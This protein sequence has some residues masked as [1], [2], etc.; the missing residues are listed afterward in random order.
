L[1]VAFYVKSADELN[2]IDSVS[3][4]QSDAASRASSPRLK[5][6]TSWDLGGNCEYVATF[7]NFPK[8]DT[9]EIT[10]CLRYTA[11]NPISACKAPPRHQM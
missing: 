1:L 10:Q 7:P 6:V 3:S 9:F 2:R 8:F 11:K 5:S 4:I